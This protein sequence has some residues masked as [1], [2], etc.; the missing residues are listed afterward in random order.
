MTNG[1][2]QQHKRLCP[3]PSDSFRAKKKQ[4][5]DNRG[6]R[7]RTAVAEKNQTAPV[8]AFIGKLSEPNDDELAGSLG[9]TKKLWD[10]LIQALAEDLG[11]KGQEW[12]SYSRKAGWSLRLKRGDRII[13]YLAP[14]R[15]SFLASFALGDR[16]IAASRKSRLPDK[17]VKIIAEARRYAEGTAVRIEV[18]SAADVA[19]VKKLAEIK[20]ES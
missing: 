6:R 16:A 13:V 19:V 12:K 7:T 10:Q 18:K 2:A 1:W 11:V 8:N 15:G 4:K 5:I 9:K 3:T 14:N 20:L 17:A